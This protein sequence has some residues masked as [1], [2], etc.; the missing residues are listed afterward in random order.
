[1]TG[2]SPT[3]ASMAEFTCG[4]I[5][6][7]VE[8]RDVSK[9]YPGPVVALDRVSLRIRRGQALAVVGAS[10]SGKSTLLHLMGTLDT[11]T[12]G[13]VLLDG[14][15]TEHLADRQLA[16]L[17][18]H[19]LGFVFQQFQLS[20]Q[21]T[22]IENVASGLLYSGVPRRQRRALAFD[23]LDLVG[24]SRRAGHLPSQLSGGERQRVAI[25]RAV[26]H[27]P[28]LLLADEPTGALDSA[29]G[30]AVLDLLLDLHQAG[31][32][33][34]VITHD[35]DIAARLPARVRVADGRIQHIEG[36]QP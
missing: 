29:T 15:H 31:T 24:L 28:L 32:T 17:R 23:A 36:L 16:A 7:A 5:P 18:S 30:R 35:P 11:P 1:M 22:A 26:A 14:H 27:R 13:E 8:L 25:A 34:V 9:T 21:L 19:H 10:G 33:L 20:D 4:D 3:V 2:S 6:P 12:S